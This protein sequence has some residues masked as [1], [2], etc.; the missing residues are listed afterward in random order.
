MHSYLKLLKEILDHGEECTDRT[1]VGTY[2]L[3]G[4]T[5]KHN[6][7]EGFPLLTT[8]KIHFKSVAHELIWFLSGDTNTKYLTDN[9]VTIWKEWATEEGELGPVYGAQWTRWPTKDGGSINQIEQLVDALKKNPYSRRHLFHAWN[10]EYLPDESVSPQ[11]NVKAGKMALPPCHLLYQFFVRKD[12]LHA[13]LTI[14]SGD[15]MLGSPFNLASLALLTHMLAEQCGYD[16]ATVQI[17]YGDV[18]LYKNHIEQVKLQLTRTPKELPQLNI[19]RKPTSIF[20]YEYED[21]EILNYNPEPPI[22]ADV[23]V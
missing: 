2:S 10:V 20:E 5:L 14:R 3:L 18:H 7:R 1:G 4:R 16:P 17:N 6:L 12:G 21:F 23:A 13:L 8:K 19:K 9:G 15:Y 11:E 22:K